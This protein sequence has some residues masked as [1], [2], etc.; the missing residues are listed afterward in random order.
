MEGIVGLICCLLCAFPLFVMGYFNKDSKTPI[1][2]WAGDKTLKE[3]VKDTRRY[4]SEISKL[5][6]RC[7]LTFV[8]TGVIC[9]VSF[10]VGIICIL[11]EST[12]GIYIVWKLYKKILSKYS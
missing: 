6:M 11:F 12:A 5:Y 4:N 2:F 10:G 9:M 7:S 3:K 8:I 1:A